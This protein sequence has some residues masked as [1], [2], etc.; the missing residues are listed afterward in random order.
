MRRYTES[1][2]ATWICDHQCAEFIENTGFTGKTLEAVYYIH[3]DA[4]GDLTTDSNNAASTITESVD[5]TAYQDD[6]SPE[7]FYNEFEV[8]GNADFDKLVAAITEKVNACV[9]A[10][11]DLYIVVTAYEKAD[12]FIELETEDLEE[13]KRVARII[14][15][16]DRKDAHTFITRQNEYFDGNYDEIDF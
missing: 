2:V 6:S 13:A 1:E 15:A 3:I 10:V 8:V 7:R 5:I 9:D 16:T 12:A 14:S 11:N 4:D